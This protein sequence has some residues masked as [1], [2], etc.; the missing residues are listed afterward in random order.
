M[1]KVHCSLAYH[2]MPL[3]SVESF[4]LG[5]KAGYFGNN[6][7]FNVLP[8]TD[9][10]YQGRIDAYIDTRAAYV[11]G[12]LGQKGAFMLAK[13]ALMDDTDELAAQVDIKADGNADIIVLAGFVPTK[14]PGE[15][16]KPGQC[17]VTVK[18]GIAGE[19]I[20]TCALVDGAKHYGC[21]MVEGG[22]LPEWFVISADGKIIVD[23]S[24]FNPDPNGMAEPNKMTGIQF[25]LTDQREKHFTG[26]THG[27]VYYFYYYA[28]NTKGVGPLSIVVSMV[29]W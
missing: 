19:L 15:G 12:G 10:A 6:P 7:P 2:E 26:L 11:N 24:K 1:K 18:R 22:E 28:V 21:I 14:T 20:A 29:A 13:K 3:D 5:V 4:A 8:F 27:A 25:D 23:K 17:I 16:Q 9:I